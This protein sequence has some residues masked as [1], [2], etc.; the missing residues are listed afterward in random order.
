LCKNG[1][2]RLSPRHMSQESP[3][4]WYNGKSDV[5][6]LSSCGQVFRSRVEEICN[7]SASEQEE[8]GKAPE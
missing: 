7:W 8:E 5:S 2:Q 1:R 3:S 6:F 4:Q